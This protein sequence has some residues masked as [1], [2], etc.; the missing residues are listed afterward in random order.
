MRKFNFTKQL[1]AAALVATVGF[2]GCQK[3]EMDEVDTLMAS[4]TQ[5]LVQNGLELKF[6]IPGATDLDPYVE[7]N[8]VKVGETISISARRYDGTAGPANGVLRILEYRLNGAPAEAPQIGGGY[9]E[10]LTASTQ[11]NQL[12][13]YSFTPNESNVGKITYKAEYTPNGGSTRSVVNVLEVVNPC[14]EGDISFNATSMTVGD[15]NLEG[16]RNIDVN[17]SLV[18]CLA[19]ARTVVVKALL[20]QPE[21]VELA[22]GDDLGL[23]SNQGK[24]QVVTWSQDASSGS[25][26]FGVSFSK[27]FKGN[28]SHKLTGVWN[29]KIYNAAGEMIAEMN[30]PNHAEFE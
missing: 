10:V 18:F 8:P 7:I 19:D 24:N 14:T 12:K 9:V 17:Y 2:F 4:S 13:N 11:V 30:S 23:V 21:E 6:G 29:A 3:N 5:M 16:I 25:Y 22:D 20:L 1:V 28:G 27:K 26:N 15:I